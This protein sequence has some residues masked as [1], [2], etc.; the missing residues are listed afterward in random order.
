MRYNVGDTCL[1]VLTLYPL[2]FCPKS[3]LVHAFY[4]NM[5]KVMSRD[6]FKCKTRAEGGNRMVVHVHF[7]HGRDGGSLHQMDSTEDNQLEPCYCDFPGQRD[8]AKYLGVNRYTR[9]GWV[10]G[11]DRPQVQ[12]MVY[13]GICLVCKSR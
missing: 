1:R 9:G 5:L 4:Q 13:I 3:R 7:H 8:T 6:A 10:S 11:C 12:C 2:E